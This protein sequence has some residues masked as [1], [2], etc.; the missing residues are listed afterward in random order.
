MIPSVV[1]FTILGLMTL[2]RKQAS[3]LFSFLFFFFFFPLPSLPPSLCSEFI[4]TIGIRA[5]EPMGIGKW[6]VVF[7]TRPSMFVRCHHL[8]NSDS[9][10]LSLTFHCHFTFA[11]CL[12]FPD[13]HD[14]EGRLHTTP[15]LF[16]ASMQWR[17]RNLRATREWEVDMYIC[18]YIYIY[19]ESP[20]EMWRS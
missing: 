15:S 9:S 16:G 20:A 19:V 8:S 5:T 1:R 17:V 11:F 18:I 14:D 12:S 6:E 3:F 7:G 4:R 13:D 2:G 10:L